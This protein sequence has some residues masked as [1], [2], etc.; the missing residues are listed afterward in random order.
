M[1]SGANRTINLNLG[2]T[3]NQNYSQNYGYVNWLSYKIP[4]I[5]KETLYYFGTFLGDI[6]Q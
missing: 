4:L 6:K 1:T 5:L 3:G 2:D